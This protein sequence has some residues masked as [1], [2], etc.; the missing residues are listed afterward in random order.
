MLCEAK[1]RQ[2]LLSRIGRNYQTVTQMVAVSSL[3]FEFTRIADPDLVLD[4][5]A[6]EVD[7][8][9]RLHGRAVAQERMHLP[10]WA[11]LWDSAMGIGGYLVK[12]GTIRKE[13]PEATSQKLEEI[14]HV[15]SAL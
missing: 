9:Q 14:R 11:E 7:L 4:Q 2:R 3:R 1:L 5:I 15:G 12:E 8:Q 13:N 6:A 10:Y